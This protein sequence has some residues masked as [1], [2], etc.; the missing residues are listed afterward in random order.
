[1]L[2]RK[3]APAG[4]FAVLIRRAV[5]LCAGLVLFA[6]NYAR[7]DGACSFT[8]SQ[9][10]P[11]AAAQGGDSG[12]PGQIGEELAVRKE[13][14]SEVV[15]CSIAE[16]SD[17]QSRVGKLA[18]SDGDAEA[19]KIQA[20][21]SG[22]LGSAINYYEVQKSKIGD[23]GLQGSKDFAA[24]LKTW[25]A[26]NYEPN[27][28]SASNFIIWVGDQ[29]IIGIAQERFD[30]IGQ[31]VS[32]LKIV[33]GQEIQSDWGDAVSNFNNALQENESAEQILLSFGPPEDS[34]NAIKS[35]LES[36]SVTYQKFFDTI[37]AINKALHPQ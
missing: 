15:D 2:R 25:R 37:S 31:S 3:T 19:K 36:L 28:K 16:A 5:L 1:M 24:D 12:A 26:G 14:L 23:L 20:Q 17:L 10:V 6:A 11:L 21:L 35:S 22:Q 32:L 4:I 8:Q 33:D 29:D 30:E 7:A 13:L 27:A 18:I 34:L 9:F